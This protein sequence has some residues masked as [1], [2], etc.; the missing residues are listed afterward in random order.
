MALFNKGSSK[1]KQFTD[2]LIGKGFNEMVILSLLIRFLGKT[3]VNYEQHS[4][5]ASSVIPLKLL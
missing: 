5:F 4:I 1:L 3:H 2:I